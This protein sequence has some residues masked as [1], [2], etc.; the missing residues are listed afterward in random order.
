M[1]PAFLG[2]RDHLNCGGL[3]ARILISLR[4]PFVHL[5]V[6]QVLGRR[7][8]INLGHFPK[9][10]MGSFCK[11]QGL[12]CKTVTRGRQ[13]TKVVLW[14]ASLGTG[15]P[16]PHSRPWDESTVSRPPFPESRNAT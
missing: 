3:S 14:A 10:F 8:L 12:P 2:E 1:V 5:V 11:H 16:L 4:T 15:D 6:K 7:Q 9:L 13:L